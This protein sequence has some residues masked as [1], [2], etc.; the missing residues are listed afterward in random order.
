MLLHD[1]GGSSL[2]A[3]AV[4]GAGRGRAEGLDDERLTSTAPG[5]CSRSSR[6]RSGHADRPAGGV[7]GRLDAVASS[8]RARHPGRAA[9]A[10]P[11]APGARAL[12]SLESS[13]SD[14]RRRGCWRRRGQVAELIARGAAHHRR[15]TAARR[16][17]S[18]DVRAGAEPTVATRRSGSRVGRP[19]R[20]PTIRPQRTD[21]L[22]TSGGRAVGCRLPRRGPAARRRAVRPGDRDARPTARGGAAGTRR[23]RQRERECAVAPR[24]PCPGDA[25]ADRRRRPR[26]AVPAS[27]SALPCWSTATRARSESSTARR[28]HEPP[29]RV[30]PRRSGSRRHRARPVG[31]LPPHLPL[32]M[33]ME[34][35]D[36][37]GD[38]LRRG[39]GCAGDVDARPPHRP[40]RQSARPSSPSLLPRC[41]AVCEPHR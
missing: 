34:Q 25:R 14:S 3:V 27:P 31:R 15:A 33:G 12:A 22:P 24:D 10:L 18:R 17:T 30:L 26:R 40:D 9:A 41:S 13:A 29:T 2:P 23:A 1:D 11:V 28:A 19:G 4:V 32:P 39:R 38:H 36:H 20:R 21:G 8:R 5:Q 6:R 35:S 37:L 7:A 16:P